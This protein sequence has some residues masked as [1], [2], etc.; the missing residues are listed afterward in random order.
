MLVIIGLG[1]IFLGAVTLF[2]IYALELR[3]VAVSDPFVLVVVGSKYPLGVRLVFKPR[4]KH[5]GNSTIWKPLPGIA[6]FETGIQNIYNLTNVSTH[7]YGLPA[8]FRKRA[9][10]VAQI[11]VNGLNTGKSKLEFYGWGDD[12]RYYSGGKI[13]VIVIGQQ[14]SFIQLFRKA[15]KEAIKVWSTGALGN[16][17]GGKKCNVWADW[18]SKFTSIYRDSSIC[19][20]EKVYFAPKAVID[21]HVAVRIKLCDGDYLYLDPH[22]FPDDPVMDKDEYEK[23]YRKPTSTTTIWP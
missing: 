19:K 4:W 12:K 1:I 16:T 2:L 3:R 10:L 9:N 5:G 8:N 6:Y 13:S 18:V 17:M 23:K 22:K 15:V 14:G 7:K 21:A 20:I 11:D